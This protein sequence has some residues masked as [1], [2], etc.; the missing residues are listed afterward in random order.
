MS[1]D[2]EDHGQPASLEAERTLLGGLL[3]DNEAFF[4][5]I[6]DLGADDFL[7]AAHRS[8]F[9]VLNDIIFGLV[10]GVTTADLVTVAEELSRRKQLESV[11]GV[12]W[13][14]S[15]TEGLPRRLKFG[16][17][18]RI[19][20]DKAK[21]RRLI[22]ICSGA[23][24]RC[25]DQ[26]EDAERIYADV[27][28]QLTAEAAEAEGSSVK[29]AEVLPSVMEDIERGRSLSTERTAAEM[30]WG[31]EGL[32]NFTRGIFPGEVTILAAESGAGKSSAATQIVL[33]NAKEGTPCGIFSIE[34]TRRLLARRFL[35]QLAEGKIITS[36][37]IRDPRLMN[38]HTHVPEVK[39]LMAELAKMPIWIDDTSPMPINKLVA[40]IRMMRRKQGIRL[41]VCDYFQLIQPPQKMNPT[42]GVTHVAFALRELV[43]REPD[44]HIIV[45]SQYSKGEG[46]GKRKRRSRADLYGG[47]AI[48]HAAQNVLLLQVE[49][50]E[51]K[52]RNDLLDV[53]IIID[54]QRDGRKGKVTCMFD[55][56][57]LSYTYAQPPLKA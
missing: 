26:S 6:A 55:R 3:L 38:A 23:I 28:D 30:T 1:G 22:S 13:L 10:Q 56:D 36:E 35:P 16:E 52:E 57:S 53:E 11:G 20:K 45:L 32:D 46:I 49:S 27:Q 51:K 48:H 41:V 50:P 17:Y 44:I 21:L 42:E 33:A 5:E 9:R 40:R 12:S 54:K 18:V 8:L 47:Q 24:N 25:A 39:R 31:I 14:A 15:L 34:M 29:L 7:L 2:Q 37:T 43:K 4:D 19:V